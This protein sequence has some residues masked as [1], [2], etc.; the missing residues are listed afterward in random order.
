MGG[1]GT[2]INQDQYNNWREQ[3]L[4]Q[5]KEL[6]KDAFILKGSVEYQTDENGRNLKTPYTQIDPQAKREYIDNFNKTLKPQV[7][8]EK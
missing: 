5:S 6:G 3:L 4:N 1:T 7:K 8:D 2:E